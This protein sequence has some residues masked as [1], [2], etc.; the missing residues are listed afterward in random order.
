MN[1]AKASS[2]S[3]IVHGGAWDIPDEAVAANRKGVLKATKAG[4]EV[5]SDGG[6]AVDAVERAV[7]MMESDETFN[8]GRGSALNAVGETELDASIMEGTWC[9]AGAV[10]AVQRIAH[11]VSLARLIMERSDNV[12]LVG[13][14]AVRFAQEHG[15]SLCG[16]DDLIT[17][18]Q[19]V[20]WRQAQAASGKR[21]VRSSG[22]KKRRGHDTVG[23]V[24]LDR[25]GHI[26]AAASTGGTPNKHPGRVGDS[27]LV[28]S[29]IY[30][31]DTLGAA[32]A[33]GVGEDII[34]VI[35]VKSVLDIME[36]N[37]GDPEAAARAGIELLEQKVQG[38][39]G[40]IVMNTK[41][42]V[43]T[44]CN[45]SRMARAYMTS[46]MRTPVAAV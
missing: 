46:G 36:R 26:V 8:A 31:D 25:R 23:A 21:K 41:G 15:M 40:I 32:V 14:G 42:Q 37:G 19:L 9:R 2:F 1:S 33:T 45:T 29:G 13:L 35:L 43:S 34:R 30:A 39:G 27:P 16:K 22:G 11:P 20:L 18:E 7:T 3:L 28:G 6:D 5:L 4:W 10:A 44:A 17:P 24:A 38:H 12:L